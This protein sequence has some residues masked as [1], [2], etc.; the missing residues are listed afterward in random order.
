MH[1][2]WP[3]KVLTSNRIPGAQDDTFT[4]KLPPSIKKVIFCLSYNLGED[5]RNYCS[6]KNIPP[7]RETHRQSC[8]KFSNTI[9][10]KKRS[11]L[12]FNQQISIK[13]NKSKHNYQVPKTL[14]NLETS[15]DSKKKLR[16]K[17]NVAKRKIKSSTPAIHLRGVF[18]K[19]AL[20]LSRI[21][22]HQLRDAAEMSVVG[23]IVQ[24]LWKRSAPKMEGLNFHSPQTKRVWKNGEREELHMKIWWRLFWI[25]GVEDDEKKEWKIA[26]FSMGGNY[27]SYHWMLPQ[28]FQLFESTGKIGWNKKPPEKP[29][30]QSFD[31]WKNPRGMLYANCWGWPKKK[32]QK[33]RK[34]HGKLGN[35]STQ[36]TGSPDFEC[37]FPFKKKTENGKPQ[38]M[39]RKSAFGNAIICWLKTSCIYNVVSTHD[40]LPSQGQF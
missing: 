27:S 3:T 38:Q 40:S 18:G 23:R 39:I 36:T 1:R 9:H 12:K 33:H 13:N 31:D 34:K 21:G 11:I 8:L 7:Q 35:P 10:Q 15:D 29:K 14:Q 6:T 16:K 17:K 32:P 20:H 24:G 26:G 25:F 2:K 5:K 4:S 28:V 30:R 37:S 22:F 19:N